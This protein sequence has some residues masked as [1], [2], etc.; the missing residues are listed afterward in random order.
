MHSPAGVETDE[1]RAGAWHRRPFGV[2][3]SM[4]ACMTVAIDVAVAPHHRR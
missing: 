4:F 1:D 2:A 3:G